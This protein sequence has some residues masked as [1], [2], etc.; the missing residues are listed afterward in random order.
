VQIC[1]GFFAPVQTK[2][3]TK[4]AIN[5]AHSHGKA[6]TQ[7]FDRHAASNSQAERRGVHRP[8]PA[9]DDPAVDAMDVRRD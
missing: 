2:G 4:G 1:A 9:L 5:L 8:A 6:T 3:A 7:V